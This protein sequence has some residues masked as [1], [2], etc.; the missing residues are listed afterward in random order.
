MEPAQSITISD[1]QTHHQTYFWVSLLDFRDSPAGSQ[2]SFLHYFALQFT[3]L[4]LFFSL[5]QILEDVFV[6]ICKKTKYTS[7]EYNNVLD[8]WALKQYIIG[9]I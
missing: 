6:N 4:L 9:T 3:L 5:I 2:M 8:V 7:V 1:G